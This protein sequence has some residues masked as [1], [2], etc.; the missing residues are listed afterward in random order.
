MPHW[1][2]PIRRST[3]EIFSIWWE[4]ARIIA[5]VAI[6]V[7]FLMRTGV[8]AAIAPAFAPLMGFYGLPPEL[9]LALLAGVLIGIWNA[10]VL[11]FLL[12]PM[13]YL[14]VADV[15]VFSALILFVHALPIEQQII[16]RTGTG[17]LASTLLRIAGGLIYAAILRVLFDATGWLSQPVA[18]AWQPVADS[19]GWAGFLIGLAETLAMMFVIL[20]A[21]MLL[22]A[23]LQRL[24][25]MALIHRLLT[26]LMRLVGIRGK[27]VNLTVIG[28]LL[29]ISYGGGLLIREARSGQIAP[30]QVFLSCTFMGFA[31]SM[32]ED[33]LV[34][35]A[36]GADAFSVL[37]GRMVF[38]MIA[39][40]LVAAVLTKLPERAPQS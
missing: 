33:T 34:V 29:G 6:T 17:M 19:S 11:L 2:A 40:A 22:M 12:V 14:S 5:P 8:I 20:V 25:I 13:D 24:G 32:I 37:A 23:L 1:T 39:T 27:A 30:R 28:L 3:A 36:L 21:L 26:P 18:P 38:A 31:H 35:M 4:L 15:T 16:R 9:A 7:E 10:A